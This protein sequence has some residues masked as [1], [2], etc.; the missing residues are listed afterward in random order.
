MLSQQD[1]LQKQLWGL[2]LGRSWASLAKVKGCGNVLSYNLSKLHV[3]CD[4]IRIKSLWLLCYSLAPARKEEI[5]RSKM[6]GF[7]VNTEPKM[8]HS[9]WST[10]RTLIKW[11][12]PYYTFL[13]VFSLCMH[14]WWFYHFKLFLIL[15]GNN[16]HR[17]QPVSHCIKALS[18]TH[19]GFVHVLLWLQQLHSYHKYLL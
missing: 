10:E 4:Q 1:H 13:T 14:F 8:R 5:N 11:I 18:Q 15:M 6:F 16:V 3:N 19:W 17:S 7:E 9:C 12:L 2:P